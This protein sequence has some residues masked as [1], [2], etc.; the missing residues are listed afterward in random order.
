MDGLRNYDAWKLSPPPEPE[1]AAVC[2]SCG[3]RLYEGDEVYYDPDGY[4]I[5]CDDDCLKN[6]V[7]EYIDDYIDIVKEAIGLQKIIVT[8]DDFI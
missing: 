4:V 5:Y 2:D 3:K 8:K 1:I 7:I 6:A